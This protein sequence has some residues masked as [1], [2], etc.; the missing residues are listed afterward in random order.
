MQSIWNDR[1]ETAQRRFF[2]SV[3]RTA[4]GEMT[5]EIM[6]EYLKQLDHA[7]TGL[8]N[9]NHPPDIS[10]VLKNWNTLD[11]ESRQ[12]FLKEHINKILVKDESVELIF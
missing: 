11:V 12:I 10:Q 8:N 4:N 1:I 9:S 5:L 7:R 3:K 6:S 2:Q